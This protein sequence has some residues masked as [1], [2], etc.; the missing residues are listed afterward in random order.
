MRQIPFIACLYFVFVSNIWAQ[1]DLPTKTI[2]SRIERVTVYEN[3]AQVSRTAKATLAAGRS[4]LTV[5]GISPQLDKQSLQVSGDFTILSVLHQT[6]FL[7]D[8]KKTDERSRLQTQ[9]EQI[10]EKV[11]LNNGLLK[12]YQQ[13]ENMLIQNQSIK[14]QAAVLKVLD[15]KEAVDFQR[16]R[17]TEL[18]TKQLELQKANRQLEYEIKRL[19]AQLT[20]I[21]PSQETTTSEIVLTVQSSKPQPAAALELTYFV[22]NAGWTPSY[23]LR[24]REVGRPLEIGYKASVYQYSG[25]DWENVKLTLSTATPRKNNQA[26][27]LRT[28]YWG[29]PN[30]YSD[31]YNSLNVAAT[32]DNEVVGTVRT[33]AERIALA[34]V[35]VQLKGTPLGTTTDANGNYRLN[36]PPD[37]KNKPKVLVFSMVGMVR[38]E[39]TVY[40]NV[41][42]A[43]LQEDKQM[44]QEVVV[45]ES[46]RTQKEFALAGTATR[47]SIRGGKSAAPLV[48]ETEAPTSQQY[49]IREL[50][51]VLSDGK[52]YG[53]EIKNEEAAVYYEYFCA[54]KIDPD[55]FL[56]A[57][58]PNWEQYGLLAGDMSVF[59]EGVFVGKSTLQPR[60]S[61]TL[62]LSLGRDKSLIVSRVKQS[63]FTKKQS[64][65][66]NQT[67]TRRYEIAV[68]NTKKQSV[69]VVITD[70][71]PLSR[72]KEVEVENQTAPEA[73]TNRETGQATWRFS[74]DPAQQRKLSLGYSVKYPKAGFVSTE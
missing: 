10:E 16:N 11:T 47:M 48:D 49:E 74:L 28:W 15:L 73:T 51:T 38:E 9:K 5:R 17:L 26:P 57:Y 13:E 67:E 22:P 29:S 65:G 31:Y 35:S 53:V 71:F 66:N 33:A 61:D 60:N 37:L 70:Q 44:L 4:I 39:K 20:T 25:E 56:T 59:F 69:N 6:S 68:R 52:T 7:S 27:T 41:V 34:G 3:G 36:I 42:D 55:V 2:E 18:L 21:A 32:T 58:L 19:N 43:D 12:V 14:G 64:L 40:Q 54:P 30:N 63:Q 45:T 23:D 62:A 50:Y 24:V 1:K 8:S 46:S 72:G